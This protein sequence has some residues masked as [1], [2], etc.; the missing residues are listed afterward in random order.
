[1]SVVWLLVSRHCRQECSADTH[2]TRH[3][4]GP[5]QDS[6]HEAVVLEVDVVDDEKARV[7]KERRRYNSLCCWISS[8][9]NKSIVRSAIA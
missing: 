6:E 2:V 8:T 3:E 1:M 5:Q 7:K 4:D 9:S